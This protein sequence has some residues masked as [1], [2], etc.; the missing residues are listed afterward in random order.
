V[1][2]VLA[3]LLLL[4]GAVAPAS[5]QIGGHAS[6]MFDVLPD[7]NPAAGRQFVGEL[8]ARVFAERRDQFGEHLRLSLAGYVD[9]LLANRRVLG[10]PGA[11][12]D[13]IV[14]P[15]EAYV[16]LVSSRFELRAGASRLV[17]GRLDEFQPTDVVNP[18]DLTRFI[19][20]GRGEARLP[21]GLLRGR[22][23]LPHAST[24]EAVIVPAFRAS[25]FDQLDEESSPFN[26]VSGA[27]RG[28][29]PAGSGGPEAPAYSLIR[30]E[31]EFGIRSVQGGGRFTSTFRRVDWG[32]SAYRG[33]RTFPV[34]TVAPTFAPPPLVTQSFPRFTMIGGDFETVHGPW[35]LRGEVA[36]FPDDELQSTR[37]IRGVPGKG[38]EG[39]VGVDRRAGDYRIAA[40]VLWSRRRVDRSSP[41]GRA[42]EGDAEIER[43]D[44]SLVIAADRSFARETRTLRAL[45][46]YD[47]GAATVFSRLIGAVSVRDNIWIEGSAGIFAGSSLDTIGRLTHRDF[48]YVRLKVFF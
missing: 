35:G 25:R 27:A 21:V 1:R 38:L 19:L 5:A 20:E 33:F 2:V 42:F 43:S 15:T 8:R 36:V 7:I 32:V 12:A 22:L 41:V 44:V 29:G 10:A 34:L 26:L 3:L 40:N 14:R 24:L 18:I 11:T 4:A 31:P 39:G 6:V 48:A 30:D 28:F 37:A 13:A 45:T 23:F 9:G 47:P 17:W 46:V 16:E